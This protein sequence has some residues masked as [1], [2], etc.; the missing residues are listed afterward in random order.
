MRTTDE[1]TL[2]R[3]WRECRANGIGEDSNPRQSMQTVP[4]L[5]PSDDRASARVD[6]C[7]LY[8]LES[9]F[10]GLYTS[11]ADTLLRSYVQAHGYVQAMGAYGHFQAAYYQDL[12]REL[13][14]RVE[15]H[16]LRGES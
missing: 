14:A 8:M 1:S 4:F 16:F 11:E 9:L 3:L 15:G 5:D 13:R 10:T 2:A 6:Q 7:R 12:L